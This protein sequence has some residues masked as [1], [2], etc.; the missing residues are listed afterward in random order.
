MHLFSQGLQPVPEML[1][2]RYRDK[3]KCYD[4]S[5]SMS[6]SLPVPHIS[7]TPYAESRDP[8]LHIVS[9]K[10]KERKENGSERVEN[11]E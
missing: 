8:S 6:P 9:R 4:L 11:W 10:K 5:L 7:Q 1:Q 2:G 3:G